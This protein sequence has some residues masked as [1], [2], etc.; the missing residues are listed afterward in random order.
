MSPLSSQTAV[1]GNKWVFIIS[2]TLL[3]LVAVGECTSKLEE[4]G[5]GTWFQADL[6][7]DSML[8][9]CPPPP[10]FKVRYC[11]LSRVKENIQANNWKPVNSSEKILLDLIPWQPCIT[12][13][14]MWSSPLPN[15]EMHKMEMRR[16]INA[17]ATPL[18]CLGKYPQCFW[19][20]PLCDHIK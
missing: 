13:Y 16:E 9:S 5:G 17:F 1:S 11:L 6:N 18:S 7:N 15:P 2:W 8:K 14:R 10:Y 12:I 4:M 3:W 20:E 19:T